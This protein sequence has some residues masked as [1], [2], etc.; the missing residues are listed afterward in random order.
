MR[1]IE[2]DRIDLSRLRGEIRQR[3]AATGRDGDDGRSQRQSQR[4]QIGYRVFPYL[5]I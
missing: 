5:G 2:V 1:L 4:R 3:V